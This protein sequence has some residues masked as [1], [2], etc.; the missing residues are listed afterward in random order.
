LSGSPAWT[1]LF[2]T[3]TPPGARVYHSAVY[4]PNARRMI[5][6]GG[7][8]QA[9]PMLND[10]WALSLGGTPA[11]SPIPMVGGPAARARHVAA[12]DAGRNLMLIH[13]GGASTT[14]QFKD[15]WTLTFTGTPTWHFQ[16]TN[17]LPVPCTSDEGAVVD[18]T[19]GHLFISGRVTGVPQ[20]V[21]WEVL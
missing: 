9:G 21:I 5:V 2:P 17:G 19:S 12:F 20:R 4:D 18:P 11:W 6:F 3:G 7:A 1:E 10:V 16:V 15:L 14:C 13:G 8:S